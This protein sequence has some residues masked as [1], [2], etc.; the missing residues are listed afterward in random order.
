MHK[1][2]ITAG[3]EAGYFRCKDA[4]KAALLA[5]DIAACQDFEDLPEGEVIKVL[6][7]ER[8]R[9]HVVSQTKI[10]RKVDKDLRDAAKPLMGGVDAADAHVTQMHG[11]RFVLTVAQ[12]NTDVDSV[13]LGSLQAYCKH[14]G[15][16]LLVAQMSYN[17][18]GF[19]QPGETAEALHYA[20]ELDPYYVTGQIELGHGAVHF[21][22]DANVLPTAKNPLSGFQSITGPGVSAVI[23]ASKIAL[24]CLA[25]LKDAPNKNLFSTGAV[26][27][28]NYILRKAGAV[29]STEHNIG[30]LFVELNQDGSYTARQIEQMP[31]F[32]GFFDE[33]VLFTPAG[34]SIAEYRPAALQFGDIHAEKMGVTQQEALGR[35]AD[36]YSPHHIICHDVMDF[37]SRNHHNVKDCA[38]MFKT[39]MRGETVELDIRKTAAVIGGLSEP[40][41]T[42][43]IVESNHDLAINTWLK[44]MDFKQDPTNALVYLRCMTALYSHIEASLP[45]EFNMLE[46]VF[47]NIAQQ[48]YAGALK[49]HKT[50]E[51]LIIAGVEMGVHGHSGLNGSRGSPAQFR[52]LGI[53]MNTGHTHTPSICG[54]VYTAGV[55]GALEMGYNVGPSSWRYAHVLTWPNG[56]RQ[57]IFQ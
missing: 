23:P 44:N 31:G 32:E 52:T 49:F 54:S 46:W 2:I 55:S 16:R 13:F 43:H 51:S 42:V 56:Q 40:G 36:Y 24:Q 34:A 7:G 28:R 39:H 35:L 22:A 4:E 50:D 30:A 53:P 25:A 33:G 20:P 15:A 19:L 11:D 38:F 26:T 18:N 48:G 9:R 27:K 47:H 17:K 1:K 12:N 57:V 14:M 8:M 5:I 37:S 29:A 10:A 3:M 6:E 45:V 21:C 41:R